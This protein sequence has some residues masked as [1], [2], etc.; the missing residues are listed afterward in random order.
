MSEDTEPEE[1]CSNNLGMG[2][3]RGQGEHKK[4][5]YPRLQRVMHSHDLKLVPILFPL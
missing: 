3:G 4:V 2:M 1:R 5:I